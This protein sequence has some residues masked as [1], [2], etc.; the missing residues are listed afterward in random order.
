[1]ARMWRGPNADQKRAASDPLHGAIA[2]RCG[3]LGIFFQTDSETGR[4]AE[5][6]TISTP[7][8]RCG[9]YFRHDIGE[10]HGPDPWATALHVAL[11]FTPFDAD[12]MAQYH[13]Y[14]DRKLGEIE[15]DCHLL[16]VRLGGALDELLAGVRA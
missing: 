2:R 8:G 5:V 6:Y 12:L 15:S 16:D 4:H 1:M 9:T 7:G 3:R 13:A 10:A 11:E 14:L